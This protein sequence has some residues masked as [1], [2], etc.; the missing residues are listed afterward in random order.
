MESFAL[1]TLVV[2]QC[3]QIMVHIRSLLK[4]EKGTFTVRHLVQKILTRQKTMVC[5]PGPRTVTQ[6]THSSVVDDPGA[7][8]SW[9]GTEDVPPV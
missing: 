1:V 3:V 9:S 5:L 7:S 4:Q 6:A 2:L 8:P